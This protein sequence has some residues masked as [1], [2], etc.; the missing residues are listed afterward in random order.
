MSKKD[1]LAGLEGL[2]DEFAMETGQWEYP[3]IGY[4]STSGVFFVGDEQLDAIDI[5]I[6]AVRRCKEVTDASGVI[7]RYNPYV[8]R[9]LMK[10]GKPAPRLQA[11]VLYN[12]QLHLFGARSW[13]ARA[14]FDNA[15][16]GKYHDDG[17]QPGLWAVMLD[18]IKRVRLERNVS[19]SPYCW[20]VSLTTGKPFQNP[21]DKRNTITP[22]VYDGPPFTFVG[23]EQALANKELIEAEELKKWEWEWT[24]A[25]GVETEDGDTAGDEPGSIGSQEDDIDSIPGFD[26]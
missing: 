1:A 17:Y 16:D 8:K 13:T 18:W 24:K 4:N 14:L 12:G 5:T 20:Q 11:V 19:T 25:A 23:K 3:T 7:W 26:L 15:K 2:G 9:H 22:I 10:E 21:Q 6:L